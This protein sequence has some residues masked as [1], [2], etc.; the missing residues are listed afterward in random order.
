M[1]HPRLCGRLGGAS[2]SSFLFASLGRTVGPTGPFFPSCLPGTLL[3]TATY[4]QAL[5]HVASLKGEWPPLARGC[6]NGCGGG[7]CVGVGQG[8]LGQLGW[9]HL[10][11]LC[12]TNPTLF[13]P[14]M[15]TQPRIAAAD[16]CLPG[17][18]PGSAVT[19]LL[20]QALCLRMLL[21][22]AAVSPLCLS[23]GSQC[24]VLSEWLWGLERM[25]TVKDVSQTLER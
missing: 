19:Q 21:L 3:N 9:G 11:L 20:H 24:S 15:W 16:G 14:L 5:S 23:G 1:G 13:V 2:M 10:P 17:D 6:S 18:S 12:I 8:F 4:A 22:G 7:V 25:E